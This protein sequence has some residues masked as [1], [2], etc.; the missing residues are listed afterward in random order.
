MSFELTKNGIKNIEDSKY[1]TVADMLDLIKNFIKDAYKFDRVNKI[2]E[3]QGGEPED[4]IIN[5]YNL[6]NVLVELI[7]G[8][9]DSIEENA[10][11]NDLKKSF[12]ELEKIEEK[13]KDETESVG[14]IQEKRRK[15]KEKE[16]EYHKI[17]KD[18]DDAQEKQRNLENS[19]SELSQKKDRCDEWIN[20]FPQLKASLEKSS[21]EYNS[22]YR[23]IYKAINSIFNEKYIKENLME[24]Y[25]GN[26]NIEINPDLSIIQKKIE[27]ID[28]FKNWLKE[29]QNRIEGLLEIYQK[30]LKNIVKL[31]ETM[32]EEVINED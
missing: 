27:N 10:F 22:K 13:L 5:A 29:I 24:A 25:G 1:I 15:L 3:M 14:D 20:N 4:I 28:D 2:T 12:S 32:T 31:S 23:Q 26:E 9:N 17:K 18:C 11:A 8:H 30:Q 6:S 19:I 21:E 7:D 16:I